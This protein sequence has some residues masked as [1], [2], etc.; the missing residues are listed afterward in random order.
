VDRLK[1]VFIT[2]WYPSRENPAGGAFVREQA[3]A[4]QAY[5]DVL[6]L[7]WAGQDRGLGQAYRLERESEQQITQDIPT[8][9]VHYGRS[10][11]PRTSFVLFGLPGTLAAFRHIVREG[12]RPDI[13]H[14]HTYT[15]G[16]LAVLLGRLYH[17]PVVITE[18]STE[19]P[20][21]SL[22]RPQLWMARIAFRQA[23]A[24]MPV[25][26]SLQHA[27]EAYGLKARFQ[28]IPN[29]VDTDL[30]QVLPQARLDKQ[31]QRLL[32]VGMLDADHK[33]GLPYLL[34][35]LASLRQ[36]RDDWQLD[37]V[38]DGP[39]RQEYEQLAARLGLDDKTVFHGMQ[40]KTQV[41]ATMQQCD[42]FVLPSLFETFG[43][44]LIEALA[45]GKP[46]IATAIGGPDEIVNEQVGLLVPPQDAAALAR[47]IEH[48]L[49]HHSEYPPAQLAASVRE[50]FSYAAVG[51][52]FDAVYRTALETE[53]P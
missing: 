8:Y 32:F 52:S 31:P 43:V 7:H 50:R 24:V 22:G 2:P 29:A 23:R 28:V 40:A 51:S 25:S 46:V 3:R 20:R 5:D 47:A 13:I 11:V 21:R 53:Q 1:V 37:I 26:R 6:V 4:V 10:P 36:R 15:S 30:F 42:F 16:F 9:R 48:M 35:A 38:G 41:A 18:H 44:V 49:D 14:A 19:F 39:V 34:Q 17:I 33:K 12:Y 27:I 45:A